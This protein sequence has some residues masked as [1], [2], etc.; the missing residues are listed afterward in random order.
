MRNALNSS[1]GAGSSVLTPATDSSVLTPVTGSSV[2]TPATD[3]SVLT[4]A[5]DSSV[6]VPV[7]VC[8]ELAE[9]HPSITSSEPIWECTAGCT[10]EYTPLPVTMSG[11]ALAVHRSTLHC[12]S[13]CQVLHWLCTGAHST[14]RHDVR[15]CTGCT[16]E[17]TPLPVTMSGVAKN[18]D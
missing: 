8:W 11:V 16:H 9:I 2:L 4:P 1:V 13:R 3:S 18:L 14:T 5:T 10:H 15:C 7:L 12:P 6:L 17:Y